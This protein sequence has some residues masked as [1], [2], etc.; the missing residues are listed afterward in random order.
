MEKFILKKLPN[1]EI[2]TAQADLK[3]VSLQWFLYFATN[4][5]LPQ[6]VGDGT[7]HWGIF[8]DYLEEQVK[9]FQSDNSL[10]ADGVVGHKT[11]EALW[12]AKNKHFGMTDDKK[13]IGKANFLKTVPCDS[14]T[15][16]IEKM[17][18]R[19]DVA[20]FFENLY[21]EVKLYGGSITSA[22]SLRGLGAKVSAGRISTSMHYPALA[23]DLATTDGMDKPQTDLY[24]I[25]KAENNK[26]TV[27][28]RCSIDESTDPME[29]AGKLAGKET[30]ILNPITYSRRNGTRIPVTGLFV[31]FTELCKK[32]GFF[33]VSYHKDFANGGS[34]MGAEW[35][36]FQNEFV[37][38]PDWSSFQNELSLI[39]APQT[40]IKNASP[41]LQSAIKKTLYYFKQNWR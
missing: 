27:Y 13:I 20:Y 28:V 4:C 18:F 36:H 38:M 12:L 15:G 22:G 26:W 40:I 6:T 14:V 41:I 1:A 31:N 37:L 21:K 2:A 24:V 30:T 8:D 10:V 3:V 32:Y 16:G 19:N 17:P 23:F 39:Y 11:M 29:F 7:G 5:F 34:Q 35:W 9:K 25:E 33:P